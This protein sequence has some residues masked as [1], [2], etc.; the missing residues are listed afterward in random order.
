MG[1]WGV[2]RVMANAILNIS[3]FKPFPYFLSYKTVGEFSCFVTEVG[4]NNFLKS[5][6]TRLRTELHSLLVVESSFKCWGIFCSISVHSRSL[7]CLFLFNVCNI[8]RQ[9][10]NFSDLSLFFVG[11]TKSTKWYFQDINFSAIMTHHSGVICQ[12]KEQPK[13]GRSA[14]SRVDG[15]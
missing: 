12:N 13:D 14:G 1:G 2:R 10:Y 8:L 11:S 15:M 6:L 9:S 4:T 5:S 7:T 3:F